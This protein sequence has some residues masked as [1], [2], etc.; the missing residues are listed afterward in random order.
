[1]ITL[2]WNEMLTSALETTIRKLWFFFADTLKAKVVQTTMSAKLFYTYNWQSKIKADSHKRDLCS[3]S[4][5]RAISWRVK[6][7]E[8]IWKVKPYLPIATKFELK[9]EIVGSFV[10]KEKKTTHKNRLNKK[11]FYFGFSAAHL[12]VKKLYIRFRKL[13]WN[14]HMHLAWNWTYITWHITGFIRLLCK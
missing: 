9:S 10:K 5:T 8:F 7:H 14:L 13:C 1:M 6:I 2:H 4:A 3:N 12:C 11:W